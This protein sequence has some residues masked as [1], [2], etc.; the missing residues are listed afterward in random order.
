MMNLVPKPVFRPVKINIKKD[1]LRPT[2]KLIV[3]CNTCDTLKAT[4]F[5]KY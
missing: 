4:N 3:N 2:V 1:V 5:T